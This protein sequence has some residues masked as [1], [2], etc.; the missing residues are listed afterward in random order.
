MTCIKTCHLPL[1]S[2]TRLRWLR[3]QPVDLPQG[4]DWDSFLQAT[5]LPTGRPCFRSGHCFWAQHVAPHADSACQRRGLL[6]VSPGCGG[7][8][9]QNACVPTSAQGWLSFFG[10]GNPSWHV[11]I[12]PCLYRVLPAFTNLPEQKILDH[13]WLEGNRLVVIQQSQIHILSAEELQVVRTIE[14]PGC[15]LCC[16]ADTILRTTTFCNCGVGEHG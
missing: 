4:F 15:G 5:Y 11:D 14:Q 13:T 2:K 1:A 7:Q 16:T 9:H 3:S 12:C 6:E 8:F 10:S